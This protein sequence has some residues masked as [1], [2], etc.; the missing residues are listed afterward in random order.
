MADGESGLDSE[1]CRQWLDRIGSQIKTKAPD[2]HAQMVE[3]HHEL[4][5]QTLRRVDEQLREEGIE[6]QVDDIVSGT[7]FAKNALLTI[8][9]EPPTGR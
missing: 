3:G 8:S 1:G 5:R 7:M 2:Q 4:F 9:R 6:V